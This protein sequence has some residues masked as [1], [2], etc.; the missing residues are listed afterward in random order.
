MQVVRADDTGLK[1]ASDNATPALKIKSDEHYNQLGYDD[2][3]IA[4]TVI[5]SQN[6][7]SW[8]NGIRVAVCDAKADQEL[9][10]VVGVNT[11]GY[12]VTQ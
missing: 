12:A 3:I 11:V 9:L 5:A 10:S 2:N 4:S 1:N 8:A 6:P 7:G